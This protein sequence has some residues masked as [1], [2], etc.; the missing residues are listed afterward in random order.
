MT[1]REKSEAYRATRSYRRM[2][3][4]ITVV[5]SLWALACFLTV[6]FPRESRVLPIATNAVFW[7]ISGLV[8][9]VAL[10]LLIRFV[11]GFMP[12][13]KLWRHLLEG[14]GGV[15]NEGAA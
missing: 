6:S 3:R 13:A 5:A 12:E 14:N 11:A 15:A 8:M 9:W 2:R 4:L 1:R 7:L 10:R